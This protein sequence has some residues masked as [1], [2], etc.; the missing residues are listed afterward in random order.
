MW[1]AALGLDNGHE[2]MLKSLHLKNI[3][4]FRDA[5]VALRPLNVLI[6]PNASGKSNLIETLGVLQAAPRDLAEFFRMNGPVSD[7]IWKGG[8]ERGEESRIA[9]IRAVVD[10][11]DGKH[12][13]EKSLKYAIRIAD[14]NERLQV[15]G[16][17]LENI[18]P[19]EGYDQTYFY[20]SAENGHARVSRRMPPAAAAPHMILTPDNFNPAKSVLSEIRSVFEFPVLTKTAHRFSSMKIYRNLNVGGNSPARRPQPTDGEVDFLREDFGNLALIVNNLQGRQTGALMDE[21]LNRFYEGY[22]RIHSRV[23]G[24]MIQLMV[25]ES[26]MSDSIPATRLSDGTLRFI[27]LL[28]ALCHPNPPDLVC[29]E[30]PEL[31][32]HPDAMPMLADLLES[33][34]ER[35]QIIA[36]THSPDLVDQF[37]TNPDAVVVCERGFDGDTQLKRL[38]EDE[39]N[40]WLEDYRLAELWKKGVIGG[41]R[42]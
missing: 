38:S 8:A 5:E 20:L 1:I 27:A 13:A 21:Y 33:A 11:P 42:W 10:N 6:G 34:S 41:N 30:E 2:M 40:D 22:G 31:A 19:H 9:E 14:S 39:L 24:G 18:A 17:R 12:P 36:T 15:V 16:E 25:N 28:T 23:F 4:S 29:I 3:L 7:W 26:G 32:L 37:T 35:T